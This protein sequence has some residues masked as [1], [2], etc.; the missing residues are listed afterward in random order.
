VRLRKLPT[1]A[2]ACPS[3]QAVTVV[4]QFGYAANII[5]FQCPDSSPPAREIT[6]RAA[7]AA[8]FPLRVK[9]ETG[10]PPEVIM[11]GVYREFEGCTRLAGT[12]LQ[13]ASAAADSHA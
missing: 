13:R 7:Q 11:I 1:A 8:P 12:V 6:P 9:D 10:A 2:P 3:A 5:S 4:G